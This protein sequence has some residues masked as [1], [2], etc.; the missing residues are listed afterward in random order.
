[1]PSAH[2]HGLHPFLFFLSVFLLPWARNS[3][4]GQ[5][6]SA[7]GTRFIFDP[8]KSRSLP[9]VTGGRAEPPFFSRKERAGSLLPTLPPKVAA[10]SRP[11]Q[12]SSQESSR[13]S[14]GVG[15]TRACTVPMAPR[16]RA[17]FD[18]QLRYATSRRL[19]SKRRPEL[20]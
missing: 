19:T 5:R 11:F 2:A 12:R 17:A 20:P 3:A 7:Q 13:P 9:T 1:M 6:G 8:V 18:G 16:W 4:H 14:A 10:A 15:L